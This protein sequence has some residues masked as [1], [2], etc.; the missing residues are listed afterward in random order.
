MFLV[1]DKTE[2]EM[3]VLDTED[4]AVDV[5]SRAELVDIVKRY[6]INVIGVVGCG[7]VG[8]CLDE[9]G[10][11]VSVSNKDRFSLANSVYKCYG[12]AYSNYNNSTKP[13]IVK[14]L[15]HSDSSFFCIL[16]NEF[17]VYLSEG[18]SVKELSFAVQK[19]LI[20]IYLVKQGKD[21][22][23]MNKALYSYIQAIYVYKWGSSLV[24]TDGFLVFVVD[25]NCLFV[26]ES[27]DKI[28]RL[29]AK[30]SVMH[31]GQITQNDGVV[32]LACEL[33]SFVLKSG[34][35]YI[36]DK[37]CSISNLIVEKGAIVHF[38]G[39][40]NKCFD[41]LECRDSDVFRELLS[42]TTY[43]FEKEGIRVD[44][45][46]L[47]DYIEYSKVTYFGKR[48]NI[49]FDVIKTDSFSY[50]RDR[51]RK[52]VSKMNFINDF[53]GRWAGFHGILHQFRLKEYVDSKFSVR[54]NTD[55]VF[56]LFK[57]YFPD[58]CG[59][60]EKLFVDTDIVK[61]I[62]NYSNYGSF[63]ANRYSDDCRV[64]EEYYT[65]NI[66]PKV[67]KPDELN[68]NS[69]FEISAN[70]TLRILNFVY[71]ELSSLGITLRMDNVPLQAKVLLRGS[72]FE[73]YLP[74]FYISL[75][76]HVLTPEDLLSLVCRL[77][78]L[79]QGI[80]GNL[81]GLN[82]ITSLTCGGYK[83]NDT[84]VSTRL[85]R[86]AELLFDSVIQDLHIHFVGLVYELNKQGV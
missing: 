53:E 31:K 52:I 9:S 26:V 6:N 46:I 74:E 48:A 70:D 33:K 39:G 65:N 81:S 63:V 8:V 2:S 24:I 75:N 59:V 66:L 47:V 4:M 49:K 18:L 38:T 14:A 16:L 11:I 64:T 21:A 86:R 84:D 19:V 22:R 28:D 82:T 71:T 54:M 51:L 77:K 42:S 5:F 62:F 15:R 80:E 78:V 79:K 40:L 13:D 34:F 73:K 3:S 29:N 72:Y 25:V 44:D 67:L 61:A 17:M 27:A 56:D 85:T 41:T 1:V 58:I 23:H 76:M 32:T 43:L 10:N 50:S 57:Q 37:G 55:F 45:Y 68:P 20:D 69:D 36:I 7:F 30:L 60:L 35:S 12:F 83:P